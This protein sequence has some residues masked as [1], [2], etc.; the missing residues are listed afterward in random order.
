MAKS[1]GFDTRAGEG[2]DAWH[3]PCILSAAVGAPEG[4]GRSK[5]REG[6]IVGIAESLVVVKLD[7]NS[8]PASFVFEVLEQAGLLGEV[9]ENELEM[10]DSG[11]VGFR[12]PRDQ[13]AAV[14]L[15]L[16]C[17]GFSD[18]RAYEVRS[19]QAMEK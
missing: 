15:A 14:V 19:S 5:R 12:V 2:H 17:S 8:A 1:H 4:G 13:M 9:S 10:V 3:N 7:G 18:V 16:E 11:T 6:S